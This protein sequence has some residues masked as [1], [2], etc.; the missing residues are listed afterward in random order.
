MLRPLLDWS[1]PMTVY[2]SCGRVWLPVF[3]AG[4]VCAVMVCHRRRPRGLERV[5]WWATLMAFTLITVSVVGDYFTPW[6]DQVFMIGVAAMMFFLASGTLLGVMLIKNWFRPRITAV[7][8][9]VQLPL[10]LLITS[11]TSLG[12][13]FIP[14]LW[15]IVIA[16]HHMLRRAE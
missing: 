14:F 12:N 8:M 3:L 1:D 6:M 13:T 2:V 5:A 10:L 9:V 16:A 4:L 7:I 15:A 11:I